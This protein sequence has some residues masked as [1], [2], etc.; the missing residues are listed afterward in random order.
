MQ[1]KILDMN[2]KQ[3]GDDS[4]VILLEYV[5]DVANLEACFSS[6]AILVLTHNASAL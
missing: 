3:R 4:N 1:I 5:C 2:K 6:A